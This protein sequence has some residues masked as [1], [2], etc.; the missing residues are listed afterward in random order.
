[1]KNLKTL[2]IVAAW[3]VLSIC[4]YVFL[5]GNEVFSGQFKNDGLSWYFLAKGIFCSLSLYLS[6]RL[7]EVIS[8]KSGK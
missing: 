4:V 5:M 7:L 8:E 6:V 1:M 2:V 3:V